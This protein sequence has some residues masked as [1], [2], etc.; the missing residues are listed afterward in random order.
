M[1]KP[2]YKDYFLIDENYFPCVNE[3]AINAGLR[4][5]GFYPHPTFIDLLKKTERILS[6]QEKR[7]LWISGA[8]GTGKSYAAY[9]LSSLLTA[10]NEE[11]E[12]YFNKYEALAQHKTD[13][14]QRFAAIKNEGKILTCYRYAS[15]AINDT[16]DLIIVIQELIAKSLEQ[17]GCSYRGENTLKRGILEWLADSRKKEFFASHIDREYKGLFG[18]WN[19]DEIIERLKTSDVSTDLVGK[20]NRMAG[21]IGI[22][23]LKLDTD[24]LIAYI[25]DIIKGNNLRALVFVLDEF[26]EF[27]QNNRGRLTDFQKLVETCVETPFYL[28]VVAHQMGS[29]FH[30]RDSDA[31]KIKDRFLSCE[32]AMPDNIAFDLMK[33]ALKIKTEAK[34]DW[35]RKIDDLQD[36]TKKSRKAVS[37]WTRISE[38]VLKGVLPL[39]P[40]SALLLK[41]ISSAFESNQRSMFDFIKNDGDYKAFQWFIENFGPLD[42]TTSLLTVDMLWDFFYATGRENLVLSIRN[43]LD[44]YKRAE[45]RLSLSEEHQVLKT[46]LIMQAVS[47]H[48]NDA[49]PVFIANEQNL[50]L[51]FEGTDHE[52]RGPAIAEKLVREEVLYKKP[53]GNNKFCY[54]T[55]IMPGDAVEL[56]KKKNDIIERLR[57]RELFTEDLS[58]VF[59]FPPSLNLRF[60]A[61][62][63]AAYDDITQETN[64]LVNKDGSSG[65]HAIVGLA[66]DEKEAALLRSS[67]KE[68]ISKVVPEGKNIVFIDTTPTP[69]GTDSIGQYAEYK[70]GSEIQRG[71]DNSAADD[72][73]RKGKGVI[74][75]WGSRISGRQIIV[76][77]K[78]NPEGERYGNWSE[79]LNGLRDLV[80]T[81]YPHAFEFSS[82]LSE[83]T[84]QP[85]SKPLWVEAGLELK[86]GGQTASAEK[87]VSE[88]RQDDKY[89]ANNPY[90]PLSIIKIAL[91]KKIEGELAKNS[92][93]AILDILGY[94]REEFG[95]VPS[96]LYAFITGFLMKEYANDTYRLSDDANNERMSVAKMKEV[97][98]EGFKQ[99]YS[100]TRN[101]RDKY[102]RIMSQEEQ[103]FCGLI[104]EVFAIP[105]NQCGSV[106]DAIKRVRARAKSYGLPFWVLKEKASGIESDFLVEF[107]K[108][109]NPDQGANTSTISGNIGKFV[110]HDNALANKLKALIKTENFDSALIDFLAGFEAGKLRQLAKEIRVSDDRV[111]SDIK[112]HFGNDTEGLWLWNEETGEGQIRKVILEYEFIKKSNELLAKDTQTVGA[113]FEAWRD[114]LKFVKVS[115]E[116]VKKLPEYASFAPAL[117]NV[118]KSIGTDGIK[119]FYD[120]IV[121]YGYSIVSFLKNDKE[122]F[123]HAC[124]FQLQGFSEAEISDIYGKI[125]INCFEMNE[126]DFI[127]KVG[128]IVS[129]FQSNLARLQ[130]RQ[131]WKEKTGTDDPREWSTRYRTPILAC[132]PT[133]KWDDFKRS[134]D[135]VSFNHSTES[136]VKFALEFLT[137]I[138]YW[139]NFRNQETV[140]RAFQDAILGRYK[141]VLTDLNE[142][143]EHLS[144]RTRVSPY[145]WSGHPDVNWL[146]QELA[147]KKYSQEPFQ[148]VIRRIDSM[149]SDK[150][151]EYLKR[152]V[153]GNMTVGIEILEDGGVGS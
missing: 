37:E 131:L 28:V 150:L 107:V 103:L 25:K 77:S 68:K 52:H 84:L 115:H 14:M 153:E 60:G 79:A 149:D 61:P 31:K 113:S 123:T 1:A 151:K 125:P 124:A 93:I 40:M 48:L 135:A 18:G 137:G 6:R 17:A 97:V 118:A 146:I 22:N 121:K 147:Q 7:S 69:F 108:L 112:R 72:M 23:A 136:E 95:F 53:L 70:A 46:I 38:R 16:N 34:A 74:R 128:E 10:S 91:D 133:G 45:Q 98:D 35:A 134:F 152:L 20:I 100:P 127:S 89:W 33:D 62:I 102:I 88:A 142:V 140:D 24:G 132:V 73:L 78:K 44:T 29:Y 32:I 15:A 126:R 96:N 56:D 117:Y 85:G 5:D 87:L 67:M 58:R 148:R 86:P 75:D 129:D 49:I 64:K 81:T 26:G 116:V 90:S 2:V 130:L 8:Y 144:K 83:V 19:T 82:G 57:T 76:Y 65:F 9:T 94:L 145:D 51:C 106:E 30:E 119:A 4:W 101:Y 59:N 63:L 141:A 50:N 105:E 41:H 47:T 36:F 114:K 11:V 66:K 54:A 104:G 12:A 55:T 42:G 120:V 39:H 21:E 139:E 80:K 71:K 99:F 143:R 3:S 43:I 122:A 109:L 27:F 92:K 138:S 111:V 13:L 110:M